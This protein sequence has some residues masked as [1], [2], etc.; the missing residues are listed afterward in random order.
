[1]RPAFHRAAGVLKVLVADESTVVRRGMEQIL[2]EEFGPLDV[3]NADVRAAGFDFASGPWDIAFVSIDL[4]MSETL[5][6]LDELKRMHP[7]QPVLALAWRSSAPDVVRALERSIEGC[8]LKESTPEEIVTMVRRVLVSASPDTRAQ[9]LPPALSDRELEVLR[10]LSSGSSMK[11]IATA[12]NISSK[13]VSTYRS[14]MLTK[15]NL[16]TTAELIRY[17]LTHRF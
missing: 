4:S 16:K 10:L 17:A 9:A 7:G 8:I 1:M 12:L 6:F 5:Q 14:R 3:T 11:E 2:V 13:T 15:L